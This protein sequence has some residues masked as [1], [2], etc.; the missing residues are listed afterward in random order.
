MDAVF[1]ADGVEISRTVL[2]A[3][4][5][6]KVSPYIVVMKICLFFLFSVSIGQ[7]GL[8]FQSKVA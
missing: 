4:L 8:I 3:C 1:P 5:S 2:M 7:F 6:L